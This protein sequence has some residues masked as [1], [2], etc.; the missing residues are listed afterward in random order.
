MKGNILRILVIWL[1]GLTLVLS[2]G[3]I[4]Y[5]FYE[6][7]RATDKIV[8]RQTLDTAKQL[9]DVQGKLEKNGEIAAAILHKVVDNQE[10]LLTRTKE[11]LATQIDEVT[12][13]ISDHQVE[14]RKMFMEEFK[15]VR[16]DTERII[17]EQLKAVILNLVDKKTYDN[18]IVE[19][20][21]VL[22]E[23]K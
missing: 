20:F 16:K 11:I 10:I 3:G 19:I 12:Q 23:N 1:V 9:L 13:K 22:K 15:E 17:A 2:V 18:N 7:S 14:S 6:N 5:N 21:R 8:Q 4:L